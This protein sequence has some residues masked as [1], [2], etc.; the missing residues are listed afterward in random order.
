MIKFFWLIPL[1]LL[2]IFSEIWLP[3]VYAGKCEFSG[4]D[5]LQ[6]FKKC[7]PSIGVK[8]DSDLDLKVTTAEW[9][10]RTIMSTIIGRVQKVT[11]VVAIGLLVW[12][13]LVLVMPMNAEAKESA[14]SKVISVLLWFLFMIAATLMVNGI[15]NLVYDLFK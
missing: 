4:G 1:L 10:F 8:P 14:K 13:G 5:I 3:N 15:I 6:D 9:D 12:I 11:A 7:N 2:M